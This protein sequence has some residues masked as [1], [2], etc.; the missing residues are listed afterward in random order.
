M[1]KVLKVEGWNWY[2]TMSAVFSWLK[3]LISQPRFKGWRT[4]RAAVTLP[5][6]GNRGGE[7]MQ[8][9]CSPS[10]QLAE[11]GHAFAAHLLFADPQALGFHLT[12]IL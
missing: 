6:V 9:L 3:Q 7:A 1:P 12:I 2:I 4:V 10:P 8:P 5:S 11:K